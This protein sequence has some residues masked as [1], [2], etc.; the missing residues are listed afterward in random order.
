MPRGQDPKSHPCGPLAAVTSPKN[1]SCHT[2][3]FQ[4]SMES[5]LATC[6]LG[7]TYYSFNKVSL[8]EIVF[9]FSYISGSKAQALATNCLKTRPQWMQ[10]ENVQNVPISRVR[11]LFYSTS[12]KHL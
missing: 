9:D 5:A 11:K 4:W 6:T 3:S 10:R 1:P 7:T 2:D 12:S 8:D